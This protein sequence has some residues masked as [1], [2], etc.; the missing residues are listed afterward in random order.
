MVRIQHI[1]RGTH[2]SGGQPAHVSDSR[3]YPHNLDLKVHNGFSHYGNQELHYLFKKKT[4][5]LH[6]T[7]THTHT[8]IY[9][10]IYDFF[11]MGIIC[12]G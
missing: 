12:T 8:H 9:I 5:E 1:I 10:Y 3:G 6:Y 2:Q 7:H 4:Q 11:I